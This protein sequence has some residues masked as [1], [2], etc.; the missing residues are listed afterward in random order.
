MTL[1]EAFLTKNKKIRRKCWPHDKISYITGSK[2]DDLYYL[3]REEIMADDWELKSEEFLA[4]SHEL[5]NMLKDVIEL[6]KQG[7][8]K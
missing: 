6:L 8:Y 5:I 3:T 7:R 1:K 2:T 4:T